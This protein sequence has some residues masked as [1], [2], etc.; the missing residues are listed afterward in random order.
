MANACSKDGPKCKA[1]DYDA[2]E[3]LGQFCKSPSPMHCEDN[4]DDD[5][6]GCDMENVQF[7][8][9]SEYVRGEIPFTFC[10]HICDNSRRMY[11]SKLNSLN[12]FLY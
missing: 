4:D 8:V 9:K 10:S 11:N 5:G 12:F 3:R 2:N 1:F 7:C 6:S